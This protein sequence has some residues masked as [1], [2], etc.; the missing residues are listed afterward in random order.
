[1]KN[2]KTLL[3]S[4]F[5]EKSPKV[6]KHVAKLKSLLEAVLNHDL[7]S[8][9][10]EAV[11]NGEDDFVFEIER[12]FSKRFSD[13]LSRENKDPNNNNLI[14]YTLLVIHL[15]DYLLNSRDSFYYLQEKYPIYRHETG[16]SEIPLYSVPSLDVDSILFDADHELPHPNLII[17]KNSADP[18]TSFFLESKISSYLDESISNFKN[19]NTIFSIMV[20]SIKKWKEICEKE[21]Y[22]SCNKMLKI[23][24]NLIRNTI[25]EF[26]DIPFKMKNDNFMIILPETSSGDAITL[27]KRIV[28]K[29]K[30]SF[31]DKEIAVSVAQ[32]NREWNK[33]KL[34]NILLLSHEEATKTPDPAIVIYNNSL[35]KVEI[36]ED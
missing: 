14:S 29:G 19:R 4:S 6:Y 12:H 3:L 28:E 27:A 5:I 13:Y 16:H 1:M 10:S 8:Q 24:S 2:H 11:L 21:S 36:V 25:R 20:V 31:D 33:E 26:S 9:T 18:L 30:K 34:L 22:D 23:T 32:Y 7:T 17:E 35:D 15:F